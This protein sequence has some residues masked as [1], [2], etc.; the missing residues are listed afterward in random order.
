MLYS[1]GIMQHLI[2][3]FTSRLRFQ[4]R[5]NMVFDFPQSNIQLVGEGQAGVRQ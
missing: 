2:Q 3:R 5:A 4:D 1:S